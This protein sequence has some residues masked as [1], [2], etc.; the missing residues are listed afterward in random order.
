[1][2]FG[3]GRIR[4]ADTPSVRGPVRMGELLALPRD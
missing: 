4:W 2:L 3:P 1:V